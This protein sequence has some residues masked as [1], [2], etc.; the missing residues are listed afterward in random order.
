MWKGNKTLSSIK[1]DCDS[2]V[3]TPDWAVGEV[4]SKYYLLK[5]IFE[6]L[7]IQKCNNDN[8]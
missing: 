4:G 8:S 7:T 2:M 1:R 6:Y 5:C 3:L